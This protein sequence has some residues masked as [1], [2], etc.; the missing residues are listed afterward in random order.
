MAVTASIALSSSSATVQTQAKT[1][2]TL[3]VSNGNSA[4]ITVLGI[5]PVVQISGTLIRAV[6]ANC[7]TP[8]T[9]PSYQTPIAA[10]GTGTYT[11]DVEMFAP[12]SKGYTGNPASIA[13]D[14]G[15][16][17]LSSDGSYIAATVATFTLTAGLT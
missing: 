16:N 10:S 8:A 5:Q 6:G 4:A 11:F 3:T 12:E 15:A 14:I 13:Y 7:G 1:T 9:G 2:A 17:V